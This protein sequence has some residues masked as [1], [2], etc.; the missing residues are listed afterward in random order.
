[1]EKYKLSV[2]VKLAAVSDTTFPVYVQYLQEA[3]ADRVFLALDRCWFYGPDE[4]ER[5]RLKKYIARFAGAGFEV[6]VWIS[7]FGFGGPVEKEN[8]D[9]AGKLTHIT[10]ITGKAAGDA[11]CPTDEVFTE[12]YRDEILSVIACGAKLVML[13]DDLCLSVRPGVGCACNTHLKLL[14]ERIGRAVE[15]EELTKC[16]SGKPN[17]VRTAFVELMGDTMRDFCRKMRDA[18]DSVDPSVRLGYCAGFTSW[19]I[20]GACPDELS[21]IL[22]GK[23]RPFLRLMGA[24]YWVTRNRFAGQRLATI[25]ESVRMQYAW[26]RNTEIEV[27]SENDSWPRPRYHTPAAYCEIFDLALHTVE[28]PGSLKYMLDYYAF[29]ETEQGY[30]KAHEKHKNL[31]TQIHA[32]FDGKTAR[33]VRVFEYPGKTEKTEF[34]ENFT[35]E[36]DIMQR[37]FSPA[38]ALLSSH[39]IPTVY[40]GKE[41]V[42]IV[43]GSNAAILDVSEIGSGLLLDF[44]AAK[45]LKERGI[46]TGITSFEMCDFTPCTEHFWDSQ[47]KINL[48]YAAGM[49]YK[50]KPADTASVR[51]TFEHGAES[52]PAA[53][54]YENTDGIRFMVFCFD[55]YEIL[56]NSDVFLSYARGRQIKKALAWLGRESFVVTASSH[57]G[58]YMICKE[59]KN[60]LSVALFNICEDSIYALKLKT[61]KNYNVLKTVECKAKLDGDIVDIES[62]IPPFGFSAITISCIGDEKE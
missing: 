34:P 26:L 18:V 53:Y 38:A 13:D 62:T 61:A 46:D 43:F 52:V 28:E 12:M 50:V 57:P 17:N 32:Q 36:Y 11:F 29:P 59:A 60:N 51:S 3:N 22:A 20:E 55:A 8:L 15:R 21:C 35:G 54:T 1:M 49:Y 25:I 10:S 42:G 27:F 40:E 58:L 5:E 30:L 41:N 16:F 37:T 19:D 33:G 4:E 31:R 39:A 56:Q 44:T 24:P 7:G 6:G 14:G 48:N 23:T 45:I 9:T 47:E 2:P